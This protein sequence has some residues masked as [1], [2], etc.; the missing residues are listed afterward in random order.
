[1][2]S[3]KAGQ[4]PSRPQSAEEDGRTSHGVPIPR[5]RPGEAAPPRLFAVA[6]DNQEQDQHSHDPDR[7]QSRHGAQVSDGWPSISSE[8]ESADTD[9]AG[10][11]RRRAAAY[12]RRGTRDRN[13][14]DT[15]SP[16]RP[17]AA[18]VTVKAASIDPSRPGRWLASPPAKAIGSQ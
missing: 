9:G 17:R 4:M 7:R 16:T 8:D 6:V 14:R 3:Q 2:S 11:G 12:Q 5:P 15:S 13:M 1:M 10:C 18:D